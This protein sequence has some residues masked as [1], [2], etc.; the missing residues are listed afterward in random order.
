MGTSR[1]QHVWHRQGT[2]QETM[3]GSVSPARRARPAGGR[4]CRLRRVEVDA[5]EAGSPDRRAKPPPPPGGGKAPPARAA[6][7]RRGGEG[8]RRGG[9]RTAGGGGKLAR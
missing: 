2:R 5:G 8:P 1:T 3:A 6:E 4:S 7:K 9:A